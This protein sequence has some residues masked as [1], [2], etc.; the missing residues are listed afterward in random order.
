MK[1]VFI[2]PIL[3]LCFACGE[4]A[5]DYNQEL[6]AFEKTISEGQ[7]G[8]YDQVK[9]GYQ[10]IKMK[11]EERVANLEFD[12][13]ADSRFEVEK[14]TGLIAKIDQS[15]EVVTIEESSFKDLQASKAPYHERI[16]LI[17]QFLEAHPKTLKKAVLEESLMDCTGKFV[18]QFSAN[19]NQQFTSLSEENTTENLYSFVSFADESLSEAMDDDV[20]DNDV[21]PTNLDDINFNDLIERF[22]AN[23]SH[24]DQVLSQVNIE[25]V[26]DNGNSPRSLRKL[27]EDYEG[28]LNTMR[29][30]R[31]D[32]IKRLISVAKDASGWENQAYLEL[33][34][35]IVRDRGEGGIFSSCDVN[36]LRNNITKA[37]EDQ[38]SILSNKVELT[39]H[40]NVSSLCGS[41]F[42]YKYYDG[43]FKLVF[44]IINNQLGEGYFVSKNVR[45]TS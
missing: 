42:K 45:Q 21:E 18:D 6:F 22:R 39:M 4:S 34:S 26:S 33:T 1:K 23:K 31:E 13:D 3:F 28:K 40:Y 19:L 41:N 32:Y 27:Y 14:L 44:P 16:S 10:Q 11:C 35:Y 25:V 38:I 15:I 17:N 20:M 37:E 24:V 43:N 8:D 29:K 36:T 2:L 5:K 7:L 30:N 9:S 12:S